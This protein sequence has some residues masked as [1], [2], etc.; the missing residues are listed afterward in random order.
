VV[1]GVGVDIGAECGQLHDHMHVLGFGAGREQR[2]RGLHVQ[3]VEC[4]GAA[5]AENADRVDHGLDAGQARQPNGFIGI[6]GEVGMDEGQVR[7]LARFHFADGADDV[8][9]VRQQRVQ[10]VLPDE[11]ACSCQQNPHAFPFLQ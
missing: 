8:M 5:F 4:L 7:V 11:P 3:L 6:V 9:A 10:Q 2:A 1:G